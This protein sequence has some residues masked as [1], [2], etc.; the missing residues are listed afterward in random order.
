MTSSI[1]LDFVK[2]IVLVEGFLAAAVIS[3]KRV[4]DH[5][6]ELRV[7]SAP[8]WPRTWGTG[9]GQKYPSLKKPASHQK[10]T[11]QTGLF[12]PSLPG[13]DLDHMLDPAVGQCIPVKY[14]QT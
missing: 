6:A 8:P 1:Q 11:V 13:L 3:L 2:R 7:S 4:P 5:S 9:I 14:K 12:T 10:S